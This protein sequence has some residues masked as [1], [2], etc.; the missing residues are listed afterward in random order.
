[1]LTRGTHPRWS[2]GSGKLTSGFSPATTAITLIGNPPLPANLRAAPARLGAPR[3]HP[4][5]GRDLAVLPPQL[6]GRAPVCSLGFGG[7]DADAS[8]TASELSESSSEPVEG[9]MLYL[10]QSHS[11]RSDADELCRRQLWTEAVR[12][13]P[14]PARTPVT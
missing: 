1:M 3:A 9:R 14:Q 13:L 5:R 8:V 2:R 12:C 4:S 10:L 11:L 6:S 7:C